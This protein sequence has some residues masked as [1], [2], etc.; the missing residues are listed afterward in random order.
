MYRLRGYGHSPVRVTDNP[1]PGQNQ[2]GRSGPAQRGQRSDGRDLGIEA[3]L[4]A[5]TPPAQAAIQ[6][7]KETFLTEGCP[8]RRRQ[9]QGSSRFV[10]V[11]LRDPHR[12]A[13]SRLRSTRTAERIT[14]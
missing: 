8:P 2:P 14:A 6:E 11:G 7:S 4:R 12:L 1:Q 13:G 9:C 5:A 10:S 3:P